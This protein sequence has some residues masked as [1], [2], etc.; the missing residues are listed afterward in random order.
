MHW[1]GFALVVATSAA[2]A[3]AA[4]PA[5]PSPS[6]HLE[7]A[8]PPGLTRADLFRKFDFR[9]APPLLR[10]AGEPDS[11]F[12]APHEAAAT[13]AHRHPGTEPPVFFRSDAKL[14]LGW[15]AADGAAVHLESG[16][17]CLGELNFPELKR[18]FELVAV[19]T[20]D[21]KGF[22]AGCNYQ[23]S[24]GQAVSLFASFWPD[25]T[26]EQH[27]QGAVAAI[28]QTTPIV[29]ELPVSVVK[30]TED[31]AKPYTVNMEPVLAGAFEI[32]VDGKPV[33]TAIWLTKTYG[34]HVKARATYAPTDEA[35]EALTAV[36]FAVTHMSVRMKNMQKPTAVGGSEV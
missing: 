30:M 33:K 23:G 21:G 35:T 31:P 16:L 6:M 2:T 7:S 19:R 5:D 17:V 34:W 26:V 4:P 9:T 15:A 20:F 29:R 32:A 22:D 12:A 27:A 14:P 18:R 3:V 11:T 24:D 28:N 1:S 25:M 8:L 10:A 13:P 36:V